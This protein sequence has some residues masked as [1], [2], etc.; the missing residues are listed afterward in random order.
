MTNGCRV[1]NLWA[2]CPIQA[3][4]TSGLVPSDSTAP[5]QDWGNASI[6]GTDS[7]QGG[8]CLSGDPPVEADAAVADYTR[9]RQP[10][11]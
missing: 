6:D 10:P 3:M 8:L 5:H 9:H 1:L 7:P 4:I 11:R 2:P